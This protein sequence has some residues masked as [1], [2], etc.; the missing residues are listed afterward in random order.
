MKTIERILVIPV[1]IVFT[2]LVSFLCVRNIYV[3]QGIS[4]YV[5][6]VCNLLFSIPAFCRMVYLFLLREKTR[7]G[8]I[9]LHE[10][11]MFCFSMSLFVV[12]LVVFSVVF[13]NNFFAGLFSILNFYS[14]KDN[15]MFFFGWKRDYLRMTKEN[16]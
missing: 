11:G 12:W 3:E 13:F 16:L 14:L 15:A 10:K 5:V 6:L 7:K 1:S 8:K 2:Y 4:W 9:V